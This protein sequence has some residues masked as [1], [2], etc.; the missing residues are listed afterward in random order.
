MRVCA[1]LQAVEA[2][3]REK[4]A[5]DIAA[6]EAAAASET[7]EAASAIAAKKKAEDDAAKAERQKK[8]TEAIQPLLAQRQAPLSRTCR[9]DA[10]LAPKHRY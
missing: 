1:R 8:A 2:A 7:A 5:A 9:R 6:A 4:A 10:L 3:Q